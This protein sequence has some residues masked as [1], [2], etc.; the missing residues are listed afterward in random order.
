MQ[1]HFYTLDDSLALA[2]KGTGDNHNGALTAVA[3]ASDGLT[4]ATGDKARDVRVYTVTEDISS[5]DCLIRSM[6]TNHSSMIT[7]VAWSP[8]GTKIV[9][10]AT[11]N[12]LC[13]WDPATKKLA[14]KIER[15][16]FT[17]I[18]SV[19]WESNDIIWSADGHG[20]ARRRTLSL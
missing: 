1:V 12:M 7:C 11:D 9:S 14:Q 6:W 19:A 8:D 15:A 2:D 16:H 18:T 5:I 3:F 13:V 20:V 4:L 17:T 10:G